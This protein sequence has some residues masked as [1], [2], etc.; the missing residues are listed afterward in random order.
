MVKK[1]DY[2]KLT[3]Q[4]EKS[5]VFFQALSLQMAFQATI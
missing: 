4:I 5:R 2:E 1:A 3:E